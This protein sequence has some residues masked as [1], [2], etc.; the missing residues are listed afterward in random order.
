M[1]LVCKPKHSDGPVNAGEDRLIKFLEVNLPSSY[2]II[3]NGEYPYI[4]PKGGAQ[5]LEFDCIVVAPHAIYVIE[6]K[7]YKGRLEAFDDAWFHNDREIKNPLRSIRF[8]GKVLVDY[9]KKKDARWGVAWVES[10]VTLSNLG[11]TKDGFDRDSASDKNT[12]LLNEDLISFLTNPDRLSTSRFVYAH[13]LSSMK[14]EITDYLMGSSVSRDHRPTQVCGMIIDEVLDRTDDYVEYLCHRKFP[15]NKKYKVRDYALNKP[16]MSPGQIQTHENL[17]KNGEYTQ[18]F[19]PDHSAV[20]IKSEFEEDENHYY[21]KTPYQDDRSLRSEMARNTF[22]E[23]HKIQVLLDVTEALSLAHNAGVIHRDVKPEN[24]FIQNDGRAALANFGLAFNDAHNM[25]QFDATIRD[26]PLTPYTSEDVYIGDYSAA[27]DVYSFGVLAYELM[28]G[29]DF[30][31]ANYLDLMAVGGRLPKDKLPSAVNPNVEKWVDELC[32]RTIVVD[33]TDRWPDVDEIR[34]FIFE[35]GLQPFTVPSGS[36]PNATGKL[37][38]LKPTDMITNDIVLAE[39]LGEGGFS[40]VFKAKHNLQ[41]G[42]LFAAKIFKEGVSPQATVDE[43][44]ALESLDHPSIV[45][46]R[47]NGI[48]NGGLFYTLMDFVDGT[49]LRRYASGDTFLPL[50]IVTKF[51]KEMLSALVY[52]QEKQPPV[53]HRDIK[54]ENVMYGRDNSFVLIDFNIATNEESDKHKVGTYRYVAPD[55]G[56]GRKTNWDLSA[57]TFALGVTLYELLTHLYPWGQQAKTPVL[58]QSPVD[59]RTRNSQISS[60]F[61]DFVMKA[62]QTRKENRFHTAREMREA[63]EAIGKV[64][65]ESVVFIDR[66]GQEYNIVDYLNSLYSQSERGN[67]GTRA[68]F[69]SE[70]ILDQLTYTPT[71]LDTHLLEDIANGEYRLIIVTGNAGDGKTAFIRQVENRG[72]GVEY[73]ESRNG[74]R[75]NLGGIRFESNY[76]GSQ[77]E[78]NLKNNDVLDKF[79]EPFAGTSD[80]SKAPE[81]RIIAINEGRLM[82]YLESTPALAPLYD[83][84]DEYFYKEGVATLPKGVMVINLNLRSITARDEN[85]MSLLRKQVKALTQKKLWTR[86]TTCHLADRCFIKYN[87]D[88][89]NDSATGDEITTRLEWIVRTIVYKRELHITMRDLRSMIAWM[90]TRDYSCVDIPHL[91]ELLDNA[92]RQLEA[93]PEDA[94]EEEKEAK[95]AQYELERQRWWLRYYFNI[96]APQNEWFPYLSSEDRLVKLLRETDIANV[97]IPELD[98]N[99]FFSERPEN[100]YLAFAERSQSLI[101]GFNEAMEIKPSFAMTPDEI[102]MMR[103]RHQTLIRHHY[104]EGAFLKDKDGFMKRLPFQSI[105][106]FVKELND[107]DADMEK[108]KNDLAY[109][110]SCS[111]GCWN[112]DLSKEHLLLSSSRVADPSA[113]SYRR[114]PLK[115]FEM[116]VDT[117]D[118]LTTYLEHENLAFIFRSK[119]KKHIQLNVSLELYEMLNY[120]EK[121]FSPSVSDLKGRFIELQV[122]KNLLESEVY[123]EI[124][125]TNNEKDYYRIQFN[126]TTMRIHVTPL[127]KEEGKE[128]EK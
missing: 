39:T 9:L 97:A 86:C 115:E 66:D 35:K 80:Y 62:I 11:Q 123:T 59:I 16:G 44:K 98:R 79:L 84:I 10:I 34:E 103:L 22:T 81:G 74:A 73:V 54:P 117:N 46:F 19:L 40:K 128:V 107:K 52:I 126:R 122:F 8:K 28:T 119:D 37:D 93:L 36:I 120:I 114:F 113:K 109:A 105:G 42:A 116:V 5:Y 72:T 6:N 69:K 87:V 23:L 78:K 50:P 118:K 1:A 104:F 90:L 20:I 68:A 26:F 67:A 49:N 33:A 18:E 124:I 99:L 92:K 3:P 108:A 58:D 112:K 65:Q 83:A 70:N 94:P 4:N 91:I 13:T 127:E 76:D 2:Y 29:H 96:T 53:I 71:R 43:F 24:V 15:F 61:A 111:E 75:F 101:P 102:K 63:F 82:E 7:D 21:V 95:R 57:D 41:P 77:D 12:F 121:G 51:V 85:G 30:P 89:F 25:E 27:S 125:V 110:I 100:D 88:S 32:E 55:L 45:K 31:Y 14:D 56:N 60:E 48:T 106:K 64:R 17:V 38:D 47:Y